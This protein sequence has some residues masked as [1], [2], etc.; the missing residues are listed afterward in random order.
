[1]SQDSYRFL[2]RMPEE[3]RRRLRAAADAS[4]KSLNREIVERLEGSL[5]AT[6]LERG[7]ANVG[8][9]KWRRPALALAF[10]VAAVVLVA[11]FGAYGRGTPAKLHRNTRALPLNGIVFKG[12]SEEAQRGGK[13]SGD[14]D[15]PGA[16]AQ[17][18]NADQAF[19]ATAIAPAQIQGSL[20]AFNGARGH[21]NRHA[22]SWQQVGPTD[23]KVPGLVSNAGFADSVQSGRVTALALSPGCSQGRGFGD[24]SILL[25][26]AGGGI[27][28]ADNALS[29]SP[30]WHESDAGLFTTAIGS[31]AYDPNDPRG[32]TVY[33]G[34]GEPN[35]SSDS[36]AGLGLF[37]SRDGGRSW[38]L[39][40]GSPAVSLGRSIGAIAIDP[41]NPNHILIGTDVARHGSSS[42]NG[43]RFTPPGAP[44]VGLYESTDGGA[45]FHLAFS[46]PSDSVDPT[47]PTGADFFRGGVSN[48]QFDPL[49]RGRVWFS[50]FD[51]GLFRSKAGPGYEQV[52]A[53]PSNGSVSDSSIARTEFALAPN[54]KK[55]RIYLGDASSAYAS[56]SEVF[57]T[58][59]GEATTPAWIHLAGGDGYCDGQCSYDMPIGSPA[60]APN[61]VWIGGAMMYGE[62]QNISNGRG[63]QRSVDGGNTFTDMTLDSNGLAL[64][65]DNHIFAFGPPGVAFIGSDG[66]VDRTSGRF[67]DTS[68]QCASRGL[69]AAADLAQCQAWLSSTPT[70]LLSL[71]DGLPT[72]QFQSLSL[73]PANPSE[74]MGGTQDNGT[75]SFTGK[76]STWFETIGGDGGESGFD[77]S[78]QT[79]MHTYFDAQVDVNFKGNTTLGWDW[80]GDLLGAEAQSFYV[81]LIADTTVSGTWFLGEQHIWR[82][83]DNGGDQAFLDQYCAEYT[84]DYAHRP[85]PCGDWQPI[86][87]ATLTGG[88]YGTDKTGA[89]GSSYVVVIKRAPSDDSTMW[90]GTRQ[91]RIFV[92]T[93]AGAP[94][95]SVAF[96]R[97]DTSA[98]PTR[99]PSG[100]VVDPTNPDHAFISY[101]GYNAYAA[102]AGTALG[103]VFDVTYNPA[104]HSATWKDI[105]Y[106]L[107][108]QPI[109][110]LAYDADSGNLYAGSDFGVLELQSGGTSWGQAA[111][112]LPLGAVYGL[113]LDP[114]N[115]VLYAATHGRGAWSLDVSGDRHG[116][117]H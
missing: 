2:L 104:T 89:P 1:V 106:D 37:K 81:P 75:W 62:I 76:Q 28:A 3:L 7:V 52:F 56:G 44:Q 15:G 85:H 64:H 61:E 46:E 51:Y 63:V 27:W 23:P 47:T 77:V 42:S 87:P 110:D 6:V 57:R 45:S 95:A 101:S 109:T 88:A 11:A 48:I 117:K 30:N 107:G 72:L 29:P 99:F 39:V 50:M 94:A 68:S 12:R 22:L 67:Q 115:D 79:R 108:D 41:R 97:I 43:G 31:L 34:T 49:V 26:A 32:R 35:G 60:G 25:G 71:N 69:A 16:F 114:K 24:C 84:G 74:L 13:A 86:G 90:A 113:V 18:Q 20:T 17:E 19:P 21:G 38:S 4:G 14:P 112:G 66:G 10:V 73:N 53:S 36:E 91:G 65:P 5:D 103:H 93:N 40:P 100:I 8:S 78:G 82:T 105:S 58:D 98:Q 80:T 33:V 111:Q 92:T 83:Q 54:G 70:Q 59:D 102:A 55:L 116:H 96:D 9:T